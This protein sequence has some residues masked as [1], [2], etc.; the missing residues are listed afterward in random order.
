LR[1]VELAQGC[2]APL[3]FLRV[4]PRGASILANL[5]GVGRR[6]RSGVAE[7]ALLD[8]RATRAWLRDCCVGMDAVEQVVVVEGPFDGETAAYAAGVGARWIV[9]APRSGTTGKSVTQL[10]HSCQVPVLVARASG[11]PEAIVAAT[12]LRSPGH[13]VLAA[14]AEIGSCLKARVVALHNINPLLLSV[15]TGAAWPPIALL[16]ADPSRA[17][18]SARL[19]RAAL[20]LEVEASAVVLN[21]PSVVDAILDEA[22]RQNADMVVV[23][24]RDCGWLPPLLLEG[25]AA[26]IV[27]RATRSV[28]VTPI[29]SF[30]GDLCRDRD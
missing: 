8:E 22:K 19:T 2:G 29:A 5:A 17:E 3:H 26:Q 24:T 13:P 23:G 28:L 9:L 18:R 27:E 4:L 6:D 21:E 20:R 25:V 15:G 11:K 10:A 7:R 14:A 16:P 1:A 30:A 12:D